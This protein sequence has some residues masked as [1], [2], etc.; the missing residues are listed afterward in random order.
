MS[1]MKKARNEMNIVAELIKRH[2]DDN[3]KKE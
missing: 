1:K 3:V 2:I